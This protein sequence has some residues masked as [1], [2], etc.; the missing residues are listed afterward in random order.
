VLAERV[1]Y[2]PKLTKAKLLDPYR[3]LEHDTINLSLGPADRIEIHVTL[4]SAC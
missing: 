4:I 3:S 1:L 2:N